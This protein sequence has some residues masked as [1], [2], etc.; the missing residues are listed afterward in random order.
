MDGRDIGP[1]FGCPPASSSTMNVTVAAPI[2]D[3]G[4]AAAAGQQCKAS[5]PCDGL[6]PCTNCRDFQVFCDYGSA[7]SKGDNFRQ[8]RQAAKSVEQRLA[9]L[10]T[11][12]AAGG[13]HAPE[14]SR[15]SNGGSS[16]TQD[17]HG[18]LD[19][20]WST[21][22]ATP[23]SPPTQLRPSPNSAADFN[24]LVDGEKPRFKPSS[25][26]EDILKDL[27]LDLSGRYIGASSQISMG[28]IISSIVQSPQADHVSSCSVQSDPEEP[29]SPKSADT[30]HAQ[31]DSSEPLELSRVPSKT[32]DRLYLAYI[33]HISKRWPVFH[34]MFIFRIHESRSVISDA[35]SLAV[36]HLVYATGG[37]FLETTGETG[38]FYPE[39]HYQKALDHLEEICGFHDVRTIQVLLLLSIYSLRSPK[40][41]GA[42]TYVGLAIRQCIEMGMHRK[43]QDRMSMRLLE[44]GIRKRVFWCCYCLDRQVSI[45]LGR[46]FAICDRDIDV[47][48]PLDVDARIDDPDELD[49]VVAAIES[50][51]PSVERLQTDLTAFIY[52][53]KLRQIESRIQRTI[54]RV[55]RPFSAATKL[56]V[57]KFIE[58]LDQ[59]KDSMPTQNGHRPNGVEPPFVD[60]YD[61]YM[62][63]YY[64]CIRFL[65]HSVILSPELAE[66]RFLKKCAEACGGV[67]QTYKKLHQTVP[68]G[69]SLM[70]LHSVFLAGLTLL[71]CTW[72]APKEIFNI[73]NSNAISSCSIILYII[74]E[75]WKGAQKYRDV[76]EAIKQSVLD[77]IDEGQYEPRKVIESL[78]PRLDTT[79]ET[80]MSSEG[81]RGEV[82]SLVLEMAGG[83][84]MLENSGLDSFG[85][86]AGGIDGV[87]NRFMFPD[88]DSALPMDSMMVDFH[89][90]GAFTAMELGGN[91]E[92]WQMH[93][94]SI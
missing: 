63:Y 16:F 60:D 27:S 67:C 69:F 21:A 5:S 6:L 91:V 35:F 44:Y 14:T 61:Y 1:G 20:S 94:G 57:E 80:V 54:Y 41:P 2:T 50:A 66:T 51:D 68:V 43:I 29:L 26:V 92:E 83:T 12:V 48:L 90:P 34:T 11:I 33:R 62:V 74:T 52:I 79:M 8:Q 37:R 58:E 88:I 71:Y 10:E 40:G 82:P 78:K 59:W 4:A 28:R 31:W 45:I 24:D 72:A 39:K 87:Q 53:T 84:G 77:S 19:R 75:R 32:A 85:Y 7:S 15:P 93:H 30:G 49:R 36:L 76:F 81:V 64:K 13:G 65:L 38:N 86:D 56:E 23:P 18:Q 89:T 73:S 46:P 47:D 70:A 55:D 9:Q 22:A 3:S 17:Q 42:W 25:R